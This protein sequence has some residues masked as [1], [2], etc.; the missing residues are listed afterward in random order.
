[1]DGQTIAVVVVILIGV[2][3]LIKRGGCCCGTGKNGDSRKK[4][5]TGKDE[6]KKSDCGCH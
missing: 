2:F 5:N 6:N 3:L 1:M 4:E